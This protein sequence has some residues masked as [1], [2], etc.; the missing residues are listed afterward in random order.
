MLKNFAY[1]GSGILSCF[2]HFLSYSEEIYLPGK[3]PSS[4]LEFQVQWEL[5]CYAKCSPKV[6]AFIQEWALILVLALQ[7]FANVQPAGKTSSDKNYLRHSLFPQ[8]SE[9]SPMAN[10]LFQSPNLESC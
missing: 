1:L 2:P 9:H 4:L 10:C 3:V 8:S 6:G 5:T 7:R